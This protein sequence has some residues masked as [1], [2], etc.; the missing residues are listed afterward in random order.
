MKCDFDLE[1]FGGE[2]AVGEGV[3]F[4]DEFHGDDG[5]VGMEG[6]RF[7]DAVIE[8]SL[9][10]WGSCAWGG[11]YDAY[12]PMPMVLLMIR[13]GRSLGSGAIWLCADVSMSSTR[14]LTSLQ[15]VSP[16]YMPHVVY[17]SL[18]ELRCYRN[19]KTTHRR[20]RGRHDNFA[21]VQARFPRISTV[22]ISEESGL[23]GE[24]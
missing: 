18:P 22:S 10:T 11:T 21:R 16:L 12:A 8:E 17:P 19:K 13:K 4:V 20:R 6:G 7:A 14:T 1:L 23:R 2:A 24:L 5:V 9:V 3:L 15:Q